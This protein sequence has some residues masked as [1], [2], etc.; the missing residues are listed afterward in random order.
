M[1]NF[2]N[3]RID[4]N[5]ATRFILTQK[6]EISILS[7]RIHVKSNVYFINNETPN[8]SEIST[9]LIYSDILISST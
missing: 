4:I 2:D 5:P 1:S 9:A 3:D 8:R 6:H 7:I